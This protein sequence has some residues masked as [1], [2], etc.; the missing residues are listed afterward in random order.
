MP[1]VEHL[2]TFHAP[3]V[4][5]AEDLCK[6]ATRALEGRSFGGPTGFGAGLGAALG[7][8]FGN[9][10][11]ATIATVRAG[12]AQVRGGLGRDAAETGRGLGADRGERHGLGAHAQGRL[13]RGDAGGRA[14]RR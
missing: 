9:D 14:W 2:A 6:L 4:T 13:D 3:P 11:G 10:L 8:G 7:L 5:G 1:Y 12:D